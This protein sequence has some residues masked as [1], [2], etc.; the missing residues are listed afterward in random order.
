MTLLPAD[1]LPLAAVFLLAGL[2]KGLLGLG[3]PTVAMGLLGLFM[4]PAEAAALL[5]LPSL[6]T[7]VWQL[8]ARPRLGP[9]LRRF[10]P[11]MLAIAAATLAGAGLI[12]GP[13]T[14]SAG[15]ALGAALGAALVLYALIGLARLRLRVP[16]AAERWA[17][18]LAGAI[19]GLVTGATGVFVVPA[20][21]YLG[22]LDLDRDDLVQALGLS[23]TVSTLAL[24]AGLALHG[25]LPLAASGRSLLAVL[26]ALA[27]MGLGGWLRTRIQPAPFRLCFFT[28]LLALGAELLWRGLR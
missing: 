2:V 18:P 13:P 17:G 27:G 7:N 6:V 25:A 1:A 21:P 5:I 24:A 9:L 8:L 14:P 28:G 26:P 4:R 12:A 15:T 20:V 19:T 10:G 22:A 16:P 3:L 11:M 23:F